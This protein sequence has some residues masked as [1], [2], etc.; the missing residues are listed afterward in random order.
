[1][2]WKVGKQRQLLVYK[3]ILILERVL[4]SNEGAIYYYQRTYLYI[5]SGQEYTL[6]T[7]DYDSKP[8]KEI[9]YNPSNPYE[10][11][12]YEGI[13]TETIVIFF[14]SLICIFSPFILK[15]IDTKKTD[16]LKQKVLKMSKRNIIK[17]ATVCFWGY[18]GLSLISV[19]KEVF[20][21]PNWS[22]IVTQ[23]SQLEIILECTIFIIGRCDFKK[24]TSYFNIFWI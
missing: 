11:E 17:I 2:S 4:G 5:V 22:Q 21:T 14:I 12:T 13:N 20:L 1:M 16:E 9:K 6:N 3:R 18:L 15:F 19:L 24:S 8:Y 10:A 7:V 23:Y